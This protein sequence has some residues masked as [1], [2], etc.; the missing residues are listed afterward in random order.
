MNKKKYILITVLILLI[1]SGILIF[2]ESRNR[3]IEQEKQQ[4]IINDL[5]I[6]TETINVKTGI[7]TKEIVYI[8]TIEPAKSVVASSKM[9]SQ[10]IKVFFTEGDTV[11]KGDI[12]A[13]LDDSQLSASQNTARQRTE[14]LKINYDYLDKE[15]QQYYISSPMIK[16]IETL[17]QNRIFLIEEEEKY[18]ALY[19][20]GAISKSA[21]EKV[22]HEADMLQMQQQEAQ[23]TSE[24]TY[25]KLENQRDILNSQL[26]EL[27]ANI[28]EIQVNIS[29]SNIVAPISGKI[30]KLNYS[31]GELA[32]AGMPFA[33]IDDISNYMV[34]VNI[35]EQDREKIKADT[36]AILN[37]TG[38]T[39]KI[40]TTVT[41]ILPNINEKTRVGELEIALDSSYVVEVASGTSV[42]VNFITDAT[43]NG[44]II[45][46]SAVKNMNDKN[47]VYIINNN[48]AIEQEIKTGLV[49]DDNIQVIEGLDEGDKIAVKNLTRIYD[50]VKIY[51]VK[52]E[53]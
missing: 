34:K 8:G 32:G 11:I 20:A 29:N 17:E 28:N 42:E 51:I 2:K 13:K 6:T 35:S 27:N 16:K 46:R 1:I 41:N 25:K 37:I 39:N 15:I 38:M 24:D 12:L 30:K 22:K 31:N 53:D 4:S 48:I 50:G 10:V 9:T 23:A 52:G 3:Q 45:P 44:I 40:E 19:E 5:G 33:I 21:Y 47:F 18:K 36:K 7:L 14:T 49:V 26:N 43:E